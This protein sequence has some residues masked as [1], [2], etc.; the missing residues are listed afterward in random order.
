MRETVI[1]CLLVA[2]VA[3]VPA[4]SGEDGG[5]SHAAPTNLTYSSNPAVYARGVPITPNA[6]TSGGGTVNGY[7]VSPALPAGLMLDA[8]S[9]VI[10]GTPTVAAAA[11]PYVVTASNSAGST[12]ATLTITVDGVQAITARH[13]TCAIVGGAVHCWG[14]GSSV[15]VAVSGFPT[16][17]GAITW[18]AGGLMVLVNGGV[19]FSRGSEGPDG[20]LGVPVAV[21]G[22]SSGTESIAAGDAHACAV[23]NGGVQCW[24]DNEF[25]KLGNGSTEDSLV[26]VAVS[27]LSSGAESVAAGRRFHSCAIV[28]GA[29]YCWG[30]GTVVGIPWRPG[31]SYVPV[32]A[33]DAGAVA[34][35]AGYDH[36]CAIVRGGARCWGGN[37]YGQ[38]GDGAPTSSNVPVAVSGLTSGVQAISAGHSHTCAVVNGGARCWGDNFHGQ[39]GNGSKTASR[40][41]VAVTGLS[42]GVQ[43]VAAGDFHSCAIVNDGV[44]CWGSNLFGALGNGSTTESLVPIPVSA[45]WP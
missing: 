38:L 2:A 43:A 13:A 26:P 32:R 40:V 37:F 19:W 20:P 45:T 42:S 4:C 15:P 28:A 29:V 33:I 44:W 9:G 34:V 31:D 7:S 35:S 12:T 14:S 30:E 6:P 8:S 3:A 39:L 16:G 25:G 17:A 22:L 18:G 24:G 11:A 23:V 41:P 5:G 10:S 27:G 1:G 36:T 21:S